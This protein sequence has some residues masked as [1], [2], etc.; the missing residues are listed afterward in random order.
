MLVAAVLSTCHATADSPVVELWSTTSPELRA[1][2]PRAFCRSYTIEGF[3]PSGRRAE[4]VVVAGHGLPPRYLGRH[5]DDVAAAVASFQP[6][7]VV[8]DTCYSAATPLLGAL[9]AK[10]LRSW[11]VAAP[12]LLPESGLVYEPGFTGPGTAEQRSRLVRTEPPYP[13]LRWRLDPDAL[14]EVQATVDRLPADQLR[15]RLKHRHPAL[16]RM[17]LPG[18]GDGMVLVPVPADRFG[19]VRLKVPA[20]TGA[21]RPRQRSAPHPSLAD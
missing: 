7:L 4:T 15:Q 3:R 14:R 20:D 11:V 16:V 17:P 1:H 8:L 19:P 12:F 13:L 10:G 6:S 18:A 9:A 21:S 5:A 2:V